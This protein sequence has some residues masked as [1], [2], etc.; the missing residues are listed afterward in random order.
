[1]IRTIFCRIPSVQEFC[2]TV[3]EDVWRQLNAYVA[4]VLSVCLI[5]FFKTIWQ[6]LQLVPDHLHNSTV[7]RGEEND[8]DE[9]WIDPWNAPLQ[10]T[11]RLMAS[12]NIGEL[13]IPFKRRHWPWETIRRRF[14]AQP[15]QD[16]ADQDG[17]DGSKERQQ[18]ASTRHSRHSLHD[19]S[20]I[21]EIDVT[22]TT[23]IEVTSHS[24][25]H[26]EDSD[27]LSTGSLFLDTKSQTETDAE[28]SPT[29]VAATNLSPKK[30]KSLCI[31]SIFGLDVG[32]TLAKL[33]Y[34][35]QKQPDFD[36]L[37]S[38]LRERHYAKA[39]SAQAVVMARMEKE[40]QH[41]KGKGHKLPTLHSMTSDSS[42]E[43]SGSGLSASKHAQYMLRRR[44]FSISMVGRAKNLHEEE[45][46]VDQEGNSIPKDHQS[47]QD[48]KRLY[49]MRQESLPDDIRQFRHSVDFHTLEE[50][51]YKDIFVAIGQ[52]T[53]E[54]SDYSG[55]VKETLTS[56]TSSMGRSKSMFDIS[57]L[58]QQK[59][60][61]LDRFY[62]FARRLGDQEDS[63]RDHKLSFYC[64]ELGGE[65]H[66]L[67]FETRRM[68]NAMDLI[69]YNNLHL[70]IQKMG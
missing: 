67:G 11:N 55:Q 31:G 41:Q 35:E 50:D 47:E 56:S 23:N 28:E 9:S 25:G 69:R 15:T 5:L 16:S 21:E 14:V 32:G 1:M 27:E 29:A 59:V 45:K 38:S 13:P 4:G 65:F 52:A 12:L 24:L 8:D 20:P 64:R 42:A 46:R 49:A 6:A 30:N 66:F 26:V 48:L 3:E 34:F 22:T 62:N 10:A 70:N 43:S 68:K 57:S 36:P 39:A 33:V 44:S 61:A 19:A 53:L 63:I 18:D 40:Q 7:P 60:E 2:Q 17:S 37:Q 58:M 51:T 54:N